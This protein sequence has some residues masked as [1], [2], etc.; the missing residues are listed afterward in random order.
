MTASGN[1]KQPTT[2][3][4]SQLGLKSHGCRGRQVAIEVAQALHYLH[5]L[6]Q[7]I[8]HFDLKSGNVL[9]QRGGHAKLADVGAP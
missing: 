2:A 3:Q 5:T 9:L 1:P 4:A 7:K 8:V 6:P